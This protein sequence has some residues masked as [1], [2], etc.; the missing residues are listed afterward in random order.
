MTDFTKNFK[1]PSMLMIINRL[2]EKD[3]IELKKSKR[4]SNPEEIH[5]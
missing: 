4:I 2:E 3:E 5:E 1:K